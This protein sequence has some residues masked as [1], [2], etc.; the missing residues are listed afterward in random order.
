[1]VWMRRVMIAMAVLVI[2]VLAGFS[3]F[4]KQIATAAFN[5]AIDRNAGVDRAADLP[6]GLHVYV[7]GSGSPMADPTRA[8]PCLGVLAGDRAYVF[9]VGSGSARNLGSMGFPWDRLETVYLT[10][11]HSDHIDGLGELL[12]QSWIAGNRKEPTPIV[13]PT[14]TVEVVGGF[15]TAYRIDST[16]R[17]AHHGMDV[18]DPSGFGGVSSEVT[19]PSGPNG[20]SVV[21]E[22]G[23]LKVTALRVDHSP[24]EPAFGYRIDYKDRSVSISGDTVF[25][26]AFNAASK[27][28]DLMFHE[29]LNK[30]MVRAIGEKLGE[31]GAA[32]GEKIFFDIIDYHTSP[33]EAAKAAQEANAGHLVLYHLVPPLP[34]KLVETVFIGDARSNFDGPIT[35][36]QDGMIFSLP[37]G[38][39]K[40]TIKRG[41]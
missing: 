22:D 36:A 12:L 31:R 3:L 34:V 23:D 13:G 15:N 21:F 10:H 33:E 38:S 40:I 5:R 17:L 37:A 20:R 27:D 14:G 32:N 9:D 1:M 18:A 19:L 35:I 8:G 16:Y 7:C 6:D 41:Y 39:D 29:A 28:V 30:D 4:K 11:L 25:H 26:P 2:L 24:I